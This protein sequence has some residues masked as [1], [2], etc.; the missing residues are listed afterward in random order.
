[1]QE[2][3][4]ST[5]TA[6]QSCFFLLLQHTP[7]VRRADS[8]TF[9]PKNFLRDLTSSVTH[10]RVCPVAAFHVLANEVGRIVFELLI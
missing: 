8:L 10:L 2:Q 9:G 5:S 1:M 7:N 6:C 4:Q 3:M